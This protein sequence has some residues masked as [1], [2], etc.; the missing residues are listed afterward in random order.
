M[1]GSISMTMSS[2]L[3][4][5]S[6][7][8]GF[9]TILLESFVGLKYSFHLS[10]QSTSSSTLAL[11]ESSPRTASAP[12]L[13]SAADLASSSI[14]FLTSFDLLRPSSSSAKKTVTAGSIMLRSGI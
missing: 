12:Y 13:P 11:T 2:S 8:V 1:P 6:H 3:G 14:A 4:S 7:H 5:Y 10:R 9:T